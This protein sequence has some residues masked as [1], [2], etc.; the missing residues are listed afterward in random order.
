MSHFTVAV[1][2]PS[3]V[4]IDDLE[5]ELT[6]ALVPYQEHA[7]TGECPEQYL[8][9]H[10]TEDEYLTQYQTESIEMVRLPDG[11][12]V[13][14][15]DD[16]FRKPGSF[17]IGGGTHEV[18][19]HLE[20]VEIKHVDRYPTFEA[21]MTDYCGSAKRDAKKGRFGYWE[22]PNHKWDYWRVGGRWRGMIPVKSD[23]ETMG[24]APAW[25]EAFAKK[26]GQK[27]EEPSGVDVSRICNIDMNVAARTAARVLGERWSS[28]SAWVAREYKPDAAD[29]WDSPRSM[30]FDYGFVEA[31]DMADQDEAV[32]LASRVA[33]G[34]TRMPRDR[35]TIVD[36]VMPI[37]EEQFK[38][39]LR[40]AFH[41]IRTYAFLDP[42]LGWVE[43]GKMGWWGISQG[44]ADSRVAY[45]E[46]F[47]TWLTSGDQND[48]FVIVDC[49]T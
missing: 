39:R 6:K 34:W 35:G 23:T 27:I 5:T 29:P 49:H 44:N 1:R 48:W 15:W 46:K 21:F 8:A 20:K 22:N 47:M 16:R 18:P 43:P 28:W 36:V 40:N 3:R 12:L 14:S 33:A 41:P 10:D 30:G 9:F 31:L 25:E 24:S 26:N 32:Q 4:T 38:A 11:A 19:A 2:I 13:Y 37:T 17:G 42:T 7:C 45:Y